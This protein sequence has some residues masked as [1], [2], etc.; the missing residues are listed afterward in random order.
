[1]PPAPGRRRTCSTGCRRSIIARPGLVGAVLQTDEVA[2]E[3]ICDGVH[4][5]PALV[6]T[7]VAAKRPPR[8]LAITDGTAAAGLPDGGQ[9]ARSA[10]GRSRRGDGAAYLADG[11]LAGSVLTMD[12][13]FRMLVERIGLSLVDAAT[14]CATTPARELGL[15][16]H[17]V[18]AVDAVAD[19]VV[20]DAQSRS[21][22][23]LRGR[24]ARVFAAVA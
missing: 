2:A 1:M 6:R 4:V 3:L 12:A 8:I 21:R 22:P 17:G 13:A 20:L 23:D 18:L 11:T 10:A 5:H 16:G 14:M 9:R 19:V 15:V 7:A 24:P